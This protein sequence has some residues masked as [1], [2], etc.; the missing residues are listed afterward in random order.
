MKITF[1]CNNHEYD[2]KFDVYVLIVDQNPSLNI[3]YNIKIIK[4]P[5]I[6]PH[7]LDRNQI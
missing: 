2:A 1:K 6:A 5:Y 3:M 4:L 7:T